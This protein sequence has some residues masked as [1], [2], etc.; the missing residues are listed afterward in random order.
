V[1]IGAPVNVEVDAQT[2]TL[3]DTVAALMADKEWRAQLGLAEPG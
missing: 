2:L 3:V 1:D